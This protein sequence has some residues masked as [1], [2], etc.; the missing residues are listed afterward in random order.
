MWVASGLVFLVT[1][2]ALGIRFAG[3]NAGRKSWLGQTSFTLGRVFLFLLLP[4]LLF[5][6]GAVIWMALNGRL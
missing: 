3:R 2:I 1:F 4:A 6:I 5:A